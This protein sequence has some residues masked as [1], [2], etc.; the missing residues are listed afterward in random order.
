MLEYAPPVLEL[1]LMRE[2]VRVFVHERW[3]PFLMNR[4]NWL[5]TYIDTKHFDSTELKRF[6][7]NRQY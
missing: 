1:V 3:T 6:F 5:G 4:F 7:A 2:R